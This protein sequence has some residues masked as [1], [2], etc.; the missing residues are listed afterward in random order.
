MKVKVG[1]VFERTSKKGLGS[2]VRVVGFQD[3]SGATLLANP[4]VT[5]RNVDT[6]RNSVM[7]LRRLE[8]TR[9][10]RIARGA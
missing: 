4:L 8:G 3:G 1:D 6:G 9:F 7:Y 10:K 5:V 2:R